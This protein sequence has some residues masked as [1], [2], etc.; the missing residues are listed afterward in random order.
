M[1]V[2]QI[3]STYLINKKTRR[4]RINWLEKEAKDKE[5]AVNYYK[6]LTEQASADLENIEAML[7]EVKEKNG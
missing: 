3:I 2:S 1:S 6:R 4:D 5:F 7:K